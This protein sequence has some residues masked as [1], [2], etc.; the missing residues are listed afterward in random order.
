MAQYNHVQLEKL[1]VRENADTYAFCQG[2]F[3]EWVPSLTV[4]LIRQALSTI[5]HRQLDQIVI[6]RFGLDG[7]PPRS[8]SKI[9]EERQVTPERIRQLVNWQAAEKIR[10]WHSQLLR[11]G[12]LTEV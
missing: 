9:A 5:T 12:Q 6:R 11:S 7:N 8:W 3:G 2:I 10:R 1:E 4:D